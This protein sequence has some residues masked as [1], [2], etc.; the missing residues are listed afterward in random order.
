MT[1][2]LKKLLTAIA[3]GLGI[4]TLFLPWYSVSIFGTSASTNAFGD[5]AWIAI[6][7]L[8]AAAVLLLLV[9]LPEKSLKNINKTIVEKERL[10]TL[11]LGG[12]MTAFSFLAMILY[13]SQSYGMG[14]MSFGF[15]IMIIAGVG[16]IVVNTLKNKELDKIVVGEKKSNTK[17]VEKK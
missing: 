12:V 16:T 7:N 1:L 6:I 14:S 2:T 8:L 15:W 17:K 11:I 3:G 4:I 13:T 10:I 9:F 5:Y